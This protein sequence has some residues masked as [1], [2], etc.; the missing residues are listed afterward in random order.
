MNLSLDSPTFLKLFVDFINKFKFLYPEV[1][2]YNSEETSAK[3]A[4]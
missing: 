4:L 1:L 3:K 2:G